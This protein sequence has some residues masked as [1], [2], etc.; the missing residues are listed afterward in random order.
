MKSFHGS[1]FGRLAGVLL[2]LVLLPVSLFSAPVTAEDFSGIVL[3]TPGFQDYQLGRALKRRLALLVVFPGGWDPH[4]IHALKVLRN[5]GP[6]LVDRDFQILIVG[7]DRSRWMQELLDEHQ[8]PFVLLSDPGHQ[9]GRLLGIMETIPEDRKKRMEEAGI[10][11]IQRT[12][13]VQ[14]SLPKLS[15]C[16]FGSDGTL[17]FLWQPKVPGEVVTAEPI[18]ERAIKTRAQSRLP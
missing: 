2:S 6:D 3:K 17:H 9:V 10:D 1:G 11:L 14:A 8:L 5:H 4:S 15:F 7:P 18:R 13:S 16:F 12:G